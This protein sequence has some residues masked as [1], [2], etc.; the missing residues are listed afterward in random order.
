MK[1]FS[2]DEINLKKSKK[3]VQKIDESG[4]NKKTEADWEIFKKDK[5]YN[6]KAKK[7]YIK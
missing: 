2:Y 3:E 4:E 5:T 6:A 1:N 7:N